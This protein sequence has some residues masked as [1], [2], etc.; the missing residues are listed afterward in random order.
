MDQC[1]LGR[2]QENKEREI[3]VTVNLISNIAVNGVL[4]R[5]MCSVPDIRR[6]YE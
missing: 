1:D 4:V 3:G 6:K 2:A 5:Y